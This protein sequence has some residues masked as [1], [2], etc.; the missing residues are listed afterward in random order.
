MRGDSGTEYLV[1]RGR[2]GES[3]VSFPCCLG[4]N[5]GLIDQGPTSFSWGSLFLW[6]GIGPDPKVLPLTGVKLAAESSHMAQ[7]LYV[8]PM[9]RLE[10]LG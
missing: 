3:P 5:P 1:L 4:W 7:A 9:C 10:S 8:P 6:S 2:G